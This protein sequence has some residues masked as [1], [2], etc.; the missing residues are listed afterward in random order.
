[1][2]VYGFA[3]EDSGTPAAWCASERRSGVNWFDDLSNRTVDV[4]AHQ[5]D[6]HRR[7]GDLVVASIHWGP[8][9]GFAIDTE[10]RR[11][12]R[13]LLERADVDLVHGHSAHHVKGIEVHEGKLILYG[14]GD[15]LNDYEGI[16]GNAAYRGELSLM[17]FPVLDGGSGKLRELVMTPTRT[18]R[19]RVN[20]AA[21]EESSWLFATLNRAGRPLG[22]AVEMQ[23]DGTFRLQWG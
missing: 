4:I 2:L 12:A 18:R 10:Q 15:F 17:Y 19:F 13:K 9:W 8:N 5:V 6:L 16:G 20:R 1:V 21:P 7:D 3:I 22:T 14:C 23:S 11:F